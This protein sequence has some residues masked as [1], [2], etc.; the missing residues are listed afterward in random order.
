M[1]DRMRHLPCGQAVNSNPFT[2]YV[3]IPLNSGSDNHPASCYNCC[4]LKILSNP[5][6]YIAT[7]SIPD[8]ERCA[9]PVAFDQSS[10]LRFVR[11]R[12]DVHRTSGIALRP[13]RP[14]FSWLYPSSG[15]DKVWR[16]AGRQ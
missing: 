5:I 1:T 4:S 9:F 13:G 7:V 15:G 10:A 12:T 14:D 2:A 6:Q 8:P 3:C 16:L 11:C